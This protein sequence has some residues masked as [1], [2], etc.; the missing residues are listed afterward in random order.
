MTTVPE[1]KS[2]SNNKLT[3]AIVEASIKDN[4]MNSNDKPGPGFQKLK[5]WRANH[6]AGT[7]VPPL[8]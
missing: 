2:V 5:I 4:Y 7:T 8:F 1:E 6:L 3:Q